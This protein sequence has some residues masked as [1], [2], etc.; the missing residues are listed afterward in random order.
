MSLFDIAAEANDVVLSTGNSGWTPAREG[1]ALMRLCSYIELGLYE[2]E[3][4]GKVKTARKVLVEFELLHED[5]R[6]IGNDGTFKGHHRISL[7]LNKS[8]FNKSNYMKVFNKLNYEHTV[9]VGKGVAPALSKFLGEPYLGTVI[10]NKNGDKT[11]ANLSKDGEYFINPPMVPETDP[12][13]GL[14]TG[15]NKLIEIP[16]MSATPRLFLW[17]APGATEAQVRE[18]WDSIYIDGEKEDGTS[19][20][21]IQNQILSEENLELHGSMV[22]EL[23]LEKGALSG[24][25]LQNTALLDELGT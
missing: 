20:N 13:T 15:K 24:V 9:S 4:Q 16:P 5:H 1:I 10:H 11:Y 23:F 17:E 7:R 18:M 21:W 3:W 19:K 6:I 2:T 12:V 25:T 22:E 14:P 8:D